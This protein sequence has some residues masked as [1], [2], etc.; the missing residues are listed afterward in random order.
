VSL[1]TTTEE[2]AVPVET[3]MVPDD[4]V[5]TGMV[6]AADDPPGGAAAP[7]SSGPPPEVAS[8]EVLEAEVANTEPGNNPVLRVRGETFKLR[9]KVPGMLL[10]QMS[11]A[12]TDLGSPGIDESFERQARA[13][14]KISDVVT[15]LVS[16]EDRERFIEWSE[17]VEPE[18]DMEAMMG[19]VN[20]MMEEIT[21]RPTGSASE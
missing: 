15:K 17:D 12:Q 3:G 7:T 11:K 19:L 5:D 18:L 16:A 1:D 13:L 10:M 9:K 8:V 6:P 14:S 2:A 4:Q 21:G 20:E